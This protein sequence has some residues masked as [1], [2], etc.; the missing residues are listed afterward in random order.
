MELKIHQR[1]FAVARPVRK[2]SPKAALRE[3]FREIFPLLDGGLAAAG[4]NPFR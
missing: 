1:Q 4:F 2:R 3:F